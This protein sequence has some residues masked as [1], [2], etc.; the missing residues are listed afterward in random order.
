MVLVTDVKRLKNKGKPTQHEVTGF[1]MDGYLKTNLDPI[2]AF[3][4]KSW[5]CVC[6]VSGHGK[7][8]IGKSTLAAQISFYMAWLLAGGVMG[9]GE[10]GRGF[11]EKK[12]DKRVKFSLKENVVFSAEDLQDR[13]QKLYE[14]YGKNQ[15]IMY[16]EG[17][18]GLDSARSMESINKGM[19]DFF[20]ECG[21]MGHIIVIVLPSFFKLKEDYAVSRSL[22]LIDVFASK[23]FE[24]GFFNFYN[25]TQKEFLYHFGK[26]K[27]GTT[28]KYLS[29][30]ESFWGRFGPWL[31]FDKKEY[32]EMKKLALEKKRKT[33]REKNFQLQRDFA[34]WMLHYT[35]KVSL[36]DI[37]KKMGEV[38][39][40][41]LAEPTMRDSTAR[42]RDIILKEK[43]A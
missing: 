17:R 42:I 6:I 20:Q 41:E 38:I 40:I 23:E 12:P 2:P 4:K 32:E 13:A 25:E 18:Q 27:I 1:Y 24:R 35:Q 29:A 39:G 9:V 8:R 10:D 37:K 31:P 33:R 36:A 7:V 5:D 15:V 26:K 43:G 16:D 34:L 30:Y 28:A 14:K 22:F 19:E 21:F 3:L 11:V